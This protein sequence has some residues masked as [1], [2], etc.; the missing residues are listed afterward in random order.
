[1]T[2]TVQE[3]ATQTGDVKTP[4]FLIGVR[5]L[6][7][8]RSQLFDPAGIALRVGNQVIAETEQGPRL[9]I[10]ASNKIVNFRKQAPCP[11]PRVL[12]VANGNDLQ[13]HARMEAM[14]FKSKSL[15]IDKINELA[16][17]M[18]LS[19]VVHLPEANKTVFYFTADGRVDFRKLI[20]EL[21]SNLKHRIEMRQV[22]VRDEA[23]VSAGLGVCGETLC[24]TRF[25]KDF[26]PVT[27]RMAKDQGLALNP[28]KISGV[29]GRLM[30]CL[31][32]E[33]DNYRVLVKGL[34]KVGKRID[35]P[36]GPGKVLKND[37]LFRKILVR[38]EDESIMT[39]HF[40]EL[41]DYLNPQNS[42]TLPANEEEP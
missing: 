26:T 2:T 6:H 11:V 12:R 37:I 10:V 18:N 32:Y 38:L 9:G 24:C 20:K 31:Q 33:H 21:A 1:M 34:P 3:P 40:D 23:R 16:L 17:P 30:C 5:I 22:G 7:Q 13:N 35:T 15:C 25:L 41:K 28:S 14:E 27:I 4:R 39:Y 29:C 42:D 19:R 8:E 36:D